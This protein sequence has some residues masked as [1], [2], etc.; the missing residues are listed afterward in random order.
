[1]KNKIIIASLLLLQA[2]MY[3]GSGNYI[4]IP[5]A[6]TTENPVSHI[7]IF[8][9][10]QDEFLKN[11]AVVFPYDKKDMLITTTQLYDQS[12]YIIIDDDTGM[13]FTLDQVAKLL[14]NPNDTF[15]YPYKNK[16]TTKY[17]AVTHRSKNDNT[18]GLIS[19]S[20]TQTP[21]IYVYG[22]KKIQYQG[23]PFD[24]GIFVITTKPGTLASNSS[25]YKTDDILTKEDIVRESKSPVDLAQDNMLNF[26]INY[27]SPNIKPNVRMYRRMDGKK[28]RLLPE[29]WDHNDIVIVAWENCWF[30]FEDLYEKLINKLYFTKPRISDDF[31]FYVNYN[32]WF[33][34]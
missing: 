17:L 11:N 9:Q 20:K 25:I 4:Q 24:Y 8:D 28:E 29:K 26:F 19:P 31:M 2:T 32:A 34:Q 21:Y 16:K 6:S 13:F 14:K 10:F 33:S 5:V 15:I 1:M 30:T 27:Q 12:K 18:N 3:S 22:S 7:K 23:M